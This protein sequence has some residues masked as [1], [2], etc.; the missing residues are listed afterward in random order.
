MKKGRPE[1][2]EDRRNVETVTGEPI[3]ETEAPGPHRQNGTVPESDGPMLTDL[4]GHI[5]LGVGIA[6]GHARIARRD[7]PRTGIGIEIEIDPGIPTV[8]VV[9]ETVAM[10]GR[11]MNVNGTGGSETNDV[12]TGIEVHQGGTG[13]EIEGALQDHAMIGMTGMGIVGRTTII[14]GIA[15]STGEQIAIKMLTVY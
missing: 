1:I 3:L 9:E 6:L 10:T 2:I 15:S 5:V 14:S 7:V 11:P 12:L 4:L 13:I 8:L